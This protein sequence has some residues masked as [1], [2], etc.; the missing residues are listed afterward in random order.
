MMI[1]DRILPLV[2]NVSDSRTVQNSKIQSMLESLED[3]TVIEL[4]TDLYQAVFKVYELYANY[5]GHMEYQAFMKFCT[6]FSIFPDI[7][8]KGDVHRIFM[9]LAYES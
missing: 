8:S 1:R 4:L 5:R 7:V 3:D 2:N 6:D 9:N